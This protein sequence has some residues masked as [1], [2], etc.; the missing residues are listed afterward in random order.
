[1]K[2]NK[3]LTEE[4]LRFLK[5][6]NIEGRRQDKY[7]YALGKIDGLLQKDFTKVTRKD[8]EDLILHIDNSDYK[9]WTKH[10]YRVV[11]KKFWTWLHNRMNEDLDEWEPSPLVKW[12]KIKKPRSSK[13]LPSELL[14]PADI[15]LLLEHCRTLRERAL[16]STL[17]ESGGRIGE[18][19]DLKIKDLIFDEHG[20]ILNVYG[21]TGYRKVRLV[22]S[23]PAISQWLNLEHPQRNDMNAY[24]F[25]NTYKNKDGDLRGKKLTHQAVYKILD[26][27]KD[28]AD[29]QKPINPHIFRHSRA[30]ELSQFLTDAQRCDFFGWTQGSQ[31][32]RV[33]T[34]LQDTDRAILELNGLIEKEKDKDGRYTSIICPRCNVNNPFGSKHCSQCALPLDDETILNYD[35][36]KELVSLLPK[37]QT[38][39]ELEDYIGEVMFRKWNEH[40]QGKK[41]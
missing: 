4:F 41:K 9:D 39:Q 23:E 27:L 29:F 37:F 19:I 5:L 32:C 17:Y 26:K 7:R 8:L 20:V 18:L 21:K 30:T 16:I 35:Q 34:H 3:S 10:D 33:Y 24:V 40:S 36:K 12:I 31:V 11:V 38:K 6:H 22:G 14:T 28:R 25:C 2:K 1:M 13:K 15:R